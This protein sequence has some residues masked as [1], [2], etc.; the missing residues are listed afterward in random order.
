[1]NEANAIADFLSS[2]RTRPL[3][4]CELAD[5]FGYDRRHVQTLLKTLDVVKVGRRVRVLLREMPIEWI[6]DTGILN[7]DILRQTLTTEKDSNTEAATQANLE[8]GGQS[9]G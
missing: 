3:E 2:L 4:L 7:S 1:M 5:A 9:N 8:H 6:A